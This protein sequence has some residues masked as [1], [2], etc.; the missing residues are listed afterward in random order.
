[1]QGSY[2]QTTLNFSSRM[3]MPPTAAIRDRSSITDTKQAPK[4]S[5]TA[6]VRRRWMCHTRTVLHAG[7]AA[8][9]MTA[10]THE[11]VKHRP[12]DTCG[13]RMI[14]TYFLG[15]HQNLTYVK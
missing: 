3:A 9:L 2:I 8:V 13:A 4:K 10:L 15:S 1:M 14:C 11:S 12:N 5:K 6:A 7:G